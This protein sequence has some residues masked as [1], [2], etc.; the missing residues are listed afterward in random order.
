MK[1]LPLS[2]TARSLVG[3]AVEGRH[4]LRLREATSRPACEA[5]TAII[6]DDADLAVA[7]DSGFA[8]VIAFDGFVTVTGVGS[9]GGM[10]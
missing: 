7:Q 9:K 4:L 8:K 6:R 5:D 10:G 2:G 3:A 1:P